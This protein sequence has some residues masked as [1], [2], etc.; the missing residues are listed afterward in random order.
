MALLEMT[1]PLGAADERGYEAG[2]ARLW[3][4]WLGGRHHG[5]QDRVAADRVLVCAPQLPYLIRQIRTMQRR[6]VRYLIRHGV[7]QF[8]GFDSG[9][10]TMGHVHEVAQPLLPDVRVV[11]VDNDPLVVQTG[12]NLLEG[13]DHTAYLC[14]SVRC[15]DHVLCH[16]DVRR[17]IDFREPVALM[18]IDTLLH[19]PDEDHPAQLLTPYTEVLC[20]GSYLGLSQFSRT[21][22]LLNGIALYTRIYGAIPSIPLRELEKLIHC[23]DGLDIVDPGIVPVPLWH[24]EPGDDIPANLEHIGVYVG[25]GRKPEQSSG[26]QREDP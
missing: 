8:L 21:Q 26:Y 15:A 7:R 20:P 22:H 23:F 13:N 6:M 12:Q 2:I 19:V 18:M 3:D 24:P 25:L 4:Y 14:A 10:P 5:E 16:P 1:I 17:L 9:I 11:Y